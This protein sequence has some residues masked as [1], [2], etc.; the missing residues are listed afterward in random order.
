[1]SI[2]PIDETLTS[3]ITPGQSWRGSDGNE[4]VLHILQIYKNSASSSDTV[5]CY[6]QATYILG[7]FWLY[8]G[9]SR[10][11]TFCNEIDP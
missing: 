10:W 2:W 7:V 1:M 9:Y 6:T 3:T 4:G 8:R 11:C 5:Y